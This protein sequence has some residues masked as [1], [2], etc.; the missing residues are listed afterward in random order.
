[1]TVADILIHLG[2]KVGAS[3]A[4]APALLVGSLLP[5]D[6]NL[7]VWREGRERNEKNGK[8]RKFGENINYLQWQIINKKIVQHYLTH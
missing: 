8:K 6:D 4:T 7:R 1:M 3:G 2:V 5:S